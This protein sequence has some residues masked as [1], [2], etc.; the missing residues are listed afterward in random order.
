MTETSIKEN[1]I[2]FAVHDVEPTSDLLP[3][4]R[5]DKAIMTLGKII[6]PSDPG[7]RVPCDE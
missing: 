5:T 3:L 7:N 1:G 2:T 4:C 6:S